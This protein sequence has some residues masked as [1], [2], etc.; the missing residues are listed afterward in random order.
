M[1]VY[2]VIGSSPLL[3]WTIIFRDATPECTNE[4]QDLFS[5]VNTCWL[6]FW[7]GKVEKIPPRHSSTSA[8]APKGCIILAEEGEK[9]PAVHWHR[10]RG[11]AV[12]VSVQIVTWLWQNLFNTDLSLS[13]TK[14]PPNLTNLIIVTIA[15]ITLVIN[16]I[17]IVFDIIITLALASL[18]A[19]TTYQH[20]RVLKNITLNLFGILVGT[21]CNFSS[22]PP[23]PHCRTFITFLVR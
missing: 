10:F 5:D 3:K 4:I 21:S 17:I 6:G 1:E 19:K 12:I 20:I 14:C 9:C 2:A 11:W 8:A 7:V 16:N 13:Y 22:C 23:P 15:N 18:A